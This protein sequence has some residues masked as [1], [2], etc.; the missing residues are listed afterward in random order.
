MKYKTIGAFKSVQN[1]PYCKAAVD[2]KVGMGVM[3][4]R[5]NELASL[6]ASDDEAKACHYIVTNINDKPEIHL[7]TELGTVLKDEYV[8]ADDLLTVANLEIEFGASEITT[9]Y[10][11]LAAND[12]LVFG[13]DGK[14]VKADVVDGYKVY[15]EII[16]ARIAYM[17][18]GVRAKICAQ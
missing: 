9:E 1:I 18:R 16:D 7:S 13:T 17:D 15:F 8:R 12:K 6:P 10:D 11:S 5:V 14:L 4:D 2:M 3:L